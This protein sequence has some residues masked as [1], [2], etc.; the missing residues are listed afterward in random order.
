M[1]AAELVEVA[2]TGLDG[3]KDGMV[4][5]EIDHD[6]LSLLAQEHEQ[7][8]PWFLLDSLDAMVGKGYKETGDVIVERSRLGPCGRPAL[9]AITKEMLRPGPRFLAGKQ[10]PDD[11][12]Y[13]LDG[14]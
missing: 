14:C 7:L 11:K 10:E 1:D 9:V 6:A 3:L 12:V 13:N 8:R 4:Y 2:P 5:Q